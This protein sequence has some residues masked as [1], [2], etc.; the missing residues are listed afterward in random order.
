MTDKAD[1]TMTFNSVMASEAWPSQGADRHVAALLAMTDHT[2]LPM[3]EKAGLTMTE[4]AGLTM[5]E[6]AGLAMT[7]KPGLAMTFT[8]VMA[9][10]AWPSLDCLVAVAPR[11]DECAVMARGAWPSLDC[12][13]AVAP[14]SDECAVMASEAWPSGLW[15]LNCCPGLFRC[16][17]GLPQRKRLAMTGRWFKRMPSPGCW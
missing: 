1:L 4:K 3:T 10:E 13:V 8:S 11:S 5:T 14:R 2:G 6:K 16:V 9:S 7:E 17:A 15:W 12:R